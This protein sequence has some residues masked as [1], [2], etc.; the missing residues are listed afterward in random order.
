MRRLFAC[1]TGC[2]LGCVFASVALAAS[3]PALPTSTGLQNVGAGGG[4]VAVSADGQTAVQGVA[5]DDFNVGAAWVFA[6]SGAGWA[7]VT[8]LTP[9][10]VSSREGSQFGASVAIS[11]DGGTILAG[12]PYDDGGQFR[13]DGAAAGAAWVFVR[14]AGG[15]WVQQSRLI[16]PTSANGPVALGS[17]V[18]LSADGDV[19]IVGGSGGAF[20][21][22]RDGSS[23]TAV[24]K[25]SG[26][27]TRFGSSVALSADG[28]S[29]QVGG[30]T[31][32]DLSGRWV[33]TDPGSTASAPPAASGATVEPQVE[34][35]CTLGT[36]PAPAADNAPN[37]II[38]DGQMTA[39]GQEAYYASL[40]NPAVTLAFRSVLQPIPTYP[41]GAFAYSPPA[42]NTQVQYWQDNAYPFYYTAASSDFTHASMPL[43]IDECS[44]DDALLMSE[45]RGLYL[46][47]VVAYNAST[48]S[49][50]WTQAVADITPAQWSE[51]NDWM[52]LA[53]ALNKKIVW[54]EPAQGW[55]ALLASSTAQG[56]FSKWGAT[57]VPMF[58]TNFESQAG[59]YQMGIARAAV[60]QAASTYGTSLGE[61]LQSWWF[62]QQTDLQAQAHAGL[63]HEPAYGTPPSGCSS[64]GTTGYELDPLNSDSYS[65]CYGDPLNAT[66]AGDEPSLTPSAS[67]TLALADFGATVGAS[68][69]QVEGTN[70]TYE[71]AAG[72][73]PESAVD[74]MAWTAPGAPSAYLQGI[75]LLSTQLENGT[76]APAQ[77]ETTALY[78]LW[79]A[80]SVTHY[81]TTHVDSKG[82]PLDPSGAPTNNCNQDTPPTTYCYQ[83]TPA[84]ATPV[85]AG[86]VATSQAAGTVALDQYEDGSQ[87]FYSTTTPSGLGSPTLIGYVTSSEQPGTEPLYQLY[88]PHYHDYFYTTDASFQR[89]NALSDNYGLQWQDEGVAAYLF[90]FPPIPPVPALTSAPTVAGGVHVG[91]T[92]SESH[93][94]WSND[95]TGYTYQWEDCDGAGSACTPISGATAQSYELQQSDLGHT[96]E[97]VEIA[98]NSGGLSVRASSAPSAVVVPPAPVATGPPQIAGTPVVGDTLSESHASWSN[99][100]TA[101][102]YQWE[103]CAGTG[104][105]CTPISGATG[106]TYELQPSDVGYTVVVAESASNAG[107]SGAP[108]LSPPTAVVQTPGVASAGAAIVH[109]KR[110]AIAITCTGG[111]SCNVSELLVVRELVRTGHRHGRHRR[112]RRVERTVTVGS[113]SATIAPGQA[114][115]VS[116]IL[117]SGGRAL[118]RKHPSLRAILST[119]QVT[120]GLNELVAVQAVRFRRARTARRRH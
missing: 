90:S 15:A 9:S 117:D 102:A 1:L 73:T 104:A 23:W 18:A 30:F 38:I 37:T 79:D 42:A 75:E 36:L 99:D 56:Y 62:R 100:P 26:S 111:T 63:P 60:A 88:E 51:L 34:N 31:F 14:T 87:F 93:G 59:G 32:T 116:V 40:A 10:D 27:G 55:Q 43:F 105:G 91:Q 118:L 64:T 28:A 68:Y 65:G 98:S 113:A 58:A 103:D 11:A 80:A 20:I 120:S 96:I 54:S 71:V 114:E 69:F 61:S 119:S 115:L 92:L 3:G 29:A 48:D 16:A 72:T 53:A 46:H 2:V 76:P 4:G 107:G 7:Q 97:A 13:P 41:G 35:A 84:G 106:E 112:V 49:G 33:A 81:Y 89:P 95:P 74:D 94:V 39:V 101:Y 17:A 110:V 8:K 12:A 52:A 67:A 45:N 70:G 19:A 82:E 5:G 21:F 44:G 109:G 22:D 77:I 66:A 85:P 86:Y 24:A 47:E 78:Q 108:T 57:L 6:R 50:N 25:L 83:D